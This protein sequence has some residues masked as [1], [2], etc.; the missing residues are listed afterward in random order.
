[1]T[2]TKRIMREIKELAEPTDQYCAAPLEV[3]IITIHTYAYTNKIE[4]Y[5]PSQG[6]VADRWV[7]RITSTIGISPLLVHLIPHLRVEGIMVALYCHQST[8]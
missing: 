6:A 7:S 1:M 4:P 5:L 2:A 3:W 8:P